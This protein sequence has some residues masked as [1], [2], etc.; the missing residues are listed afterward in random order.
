M[1]WNDVKIGDR[2]T[3]TYQGHE[4][5]ADVYY[6]EYENVRV[7]TNLL[8]DVNK[9]VLT[10]VD[11]PTRTLPTEPG[12]VILDVVTDEGEYSIAVKQNDDYWWFLPTSP[13][14]DNHYIYPGDIL[15]FT[16]ARVVPDE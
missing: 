10:N 2:V 3:F 12:S 11:R 4:V 5:V 9:Y 13:P 1:N 6:D 16:P 15:S 8:Y 7:G 14:E